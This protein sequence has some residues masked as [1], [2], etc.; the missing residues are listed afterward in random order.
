MLDVPGEAVA[1]EPSIPGVIFRGRSRK[2]VNP[3]PPVNDAWRPAARA[4]E[5]TVFEAC[6]P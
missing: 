2:S 1:Y 3:T 4:G 5:F 6:A